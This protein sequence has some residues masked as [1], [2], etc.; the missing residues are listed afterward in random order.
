[1][2][3][4]DVIDRWA[5]IRPEATA[6][7]VLGAG[8]HAEASI[9]YGALL[10]GARGLAAAIEARVAPGERLLVMMP[11]GIGFML[12]YLASLVAGTIAVPV[13]VPRPQRT[14]ERLKLIIRDCAPAAAIV[15]SADM[16]SAY[17]EA[18]GAEG[19]S[20]RWLS[21]DHAAST[22]V[23][24]GARSVTAE[25]VA[26]LQ[27]TSGSTASPKGVKLTHGN[28]LHNQAMIDAVFRMDDR[29]VVLGWLP[30]FHDMGLIGIALHPLYK[31]VRGILLSPDSFVG[32]PL[33][34]LRAISDHGAT[35]SG[36][37]NFAYELCARFV[38][39]RDKRG[40]DLSRLRI[41]FSGSERVRPQ[42]LT[43]FEQAF[44]DCGFR[45]TSFLPCYGMAEATLMISGYPSGEPPVVRQVK[46]RA[47]QEGHRIV[48]AGDDRDAIGL[49][50]VGRTL[51][52]E[53]IVIVEPSGLGRREDREIG[54]VW[55]AGP[56]V[57]DG[58]W[59]SSEDARIRPSWDAG[60]DYLR[61]GDLGYIDD[62]D[63][64]ITGRL[65][66]LIIIRG[67]NIHPEDVEIAVESCLA[68]AVSGRIAAFSVE[69]DNE[70]RLVIAFE[71]NPHRELTIDTLAGDVR[72]ALG[73]RFEV[74]LHAL[75]AVKRGSLPLTS[76]GKLRRNHVR[77]LW[78]EQGL[79]VVAQ[80]RPGDPADAVE[81]QPTRA[82]LARATREEARSLLSGVLID[83]IR[84]FGGMDRL[85]DQAL[86]SSSLPGLGLGSLQIIRLIHRIDECCGVRIALA[87]SLEVS[88]LD[89]LVDLIV[90][91]LGETAQRSDAV[92]VDDARVVAT[93]PLSLGQQG[94]WFA[95]Q[96]SPRS[97][98]YQI[99]RAADVSPVID[100][101]AMNRAL[102][103]LVRCHPALRLAIDP[104]SDGE[105]PMQRL[106]PDAP[107][108]VRLLSCDSPAERDRVLRA[109]ARTSFDLSVAP[110][111]RVSVLRAPG[112]H[113]L[114]ALVAH[115]IICDL[116]S[117]SVLMHD[118]LRVYRD[119]LAGGPQTS[120]SDGPTY[121]DQVLE[122]HARASTDDWR[123]RMD[124]WTR[125]LGDAD[126]WTR[127][128][129]A[130]AAEEVPALHT[131][132]R[133]VRRE[134][135]QKLR[136]LARRHDM[137]LQMVLFAAFQLAVAVL[138]GRDGFLACT[139]TSGRER[140]DR[141]RM[142]G[143]FANLLLF[144]VRVDRRDSIAQW[145]RATRRQMLD[146]YANE[147]PYEEVIRGCANRHA[148]ERPV[149]YAFVM[150]DEGAAD[151]PG[152][153]P[154]SLGQAGGRWTAGE[155]E[156]TSVAFEE[157]HAQF[158]LALYAGVDQDSLLY[159]YKASGP[160]VT[161]QQ[162]YAVAHLVER[163][164]EWLASEDVDDRRLS[165]LQW[166]DPDERRLFDEQAE[167][168]R[169][170]AYL[171]PQHLLDQFERQCV[172]TP[173][174]IALEFE[175]ASTTYAHLQARVLRMASHLRSRGV[176]C[177]TIVGVCMHRS[178]DMV[179]AIYGVLK[180]G[181][182]YLPLD[183][184][185]PAEYLA[186]LVSEA[187]LRYVV[188]DGTLVAQL[189][190]TLPD[191]E[192][193][194]V[195]AP[196]PAVSDDGCPPPL[197][198]QLAYVIFTSGSTGAPK[199][200]MNTHAG[201]VNRLL[202]MQERYRLDES[203]TLVQKT[204]F[205]F[206]VSVWE[207]FWPLM[208]G[209]RLV[210]AR[211][212]GHKDT[213]YLAGLLTGRMVTLVHF[214]PSMLR[215][216]LLEERCVSCRALHTVICSGEALPTRLVREL[217]GRLPVRVEN[218]YGPTEASVDV[219]YYPC[220]ENW[221]GAIQPIG[222]AIANTRLHVLDAA[223][224][225]LP[226]DVTG[227]LCISGVG[228]AR[229]YLANPSLTAE[230]FLPD[231]AG[232]AGARC[233]DT[234]DR[235]KFRQPDLIE[236]CGR[237]D[238]QVK[239]RGLRIELSEIE[240]VL[241]RHACILAAAVTVRQGPAT[242]ATLRYVDRDPPE[243]QWGALLDHRTFLRGNLATAEA[244][245]LPSQLV[246]YCVRTAGAAL[247]VESIQQWVRARLP[248][249]SVPA[250]VVFV[251]QL[252]V[253]A[254]GKLDKAR[255]PEPDSLRPSLR[256]A[257]CAPRTVTER[258]LVD[259]WER[260]LDVRGI[261]IR[262]NFFALGGD[263]IRAL[264]LVSQ[265]AQAGIVFD[266]ATLFAHPT[267]EQLAECAATA[268]EPVRHTPVERFSL[269]G[270]N[271]R[272][273]VPDGI[274]DAY[275]LAVVQAGLIFHDEVAA[276][277]REV[278]KDV[279][280]Y[281]IRAPFDE[282]TFRQAIATLIERHEILRASIDLLNFS[283]PVQ[284]VHPQAQASVEVTRLDHVGGAADTGAFAA[285]L[286]SQAFDWSRPPFIRFAIVLRADA[287]FE[288]FVVFHDLLLDGWSASQLVSELLL[289]Y[290][291]LL[292]GGNPVS[293]PALRVRFAD[294]VA[295]ELEASRSAEARAFFA[296]YLADA[297]E[298]RF[299]VRE[300]DDVTVPRFAVLDVPIALATSD[301]LREMAANCGVGIKHVL[302]AAH[303]A[304][305]SQLFGERDILTGLESNGR[306]ETE[307][308]DMVIGM[309]LNT[310]P[311]RIRCA[312]GRWRDL[313]GEVYRIEQLLTPMRRYPYANMQRMLGTGD[314]V[315]TVFNYVHFHGFRRLLQL[316]HLQVQEARGYGASHFKYRSEFSTDPFSGRIH[317]CL[318]CDTRAVT[319][320]LIHE[321]GRY[322]A[323]VLEVM[324][325]DPEARYDQMSLTR[326]AP[327][328][329]APVSVAGREAEAA[330][331]WLTPWRQ[332]LHH[333]GDRIALV[334]GPHRTSC[335]AMQHRA[336][337]W[338]RA[339]TRRGVGPE[340]C[341]GV[342]VRDPIA[343]AVAILA[344]HL[345]GGAYVPL[346]L[347]HPAERN[348]QIL[349]TGGIAWVIVDDLDALG[350][351]I[352]STI[353][354]VELIAPHGLDAEACE[355]SPD[356]RASAPDQLG[357]D[358]LSPDLLSYVIYTSGSTGSPKGVMVT[359]ANLWFSLRSRMEYYARPEPMVFLM[360]PPF[361]FDSSVGVFFWSLAGGHRLVF[362]ET[363]VSDLLSVLRTIREEAV[364]HVLCTPSYYGALLAE[365]SDGDLESLETIIM[366]G[367]PLSRQL[368]IEHGARLPSAVMFN[369]YGPTEG[370][371]WSSVHRCGDDAHHVPIGKPRDYTSA[372]ILDRRQLAATPG[373]SGELVIGGTGVARGYVNAP[374]ATAAAFVPDPSAAVPGGR[375]YAT[376]DL[377]RG[378]RGVITLLGRND[379]QIKINGY[380][381]E[382]DEIEH[383][384]RQ[385][386]AIED[387]AV[388]YDAHAG[389]SARIIA[390][391][392]PTEEWTSDLEGLDA[393]LP[394]YMVPGR[395]LPLGTLP[396]N[397]NGKVDYRCL[398]DQGEQLSGEWQ[399][400]RILDE[401]ER[402]TEQDVVRALER[403]AA[404]PAENSTHG[405]AG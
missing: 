78:S 295:S 375:A 397:A 268:V 323:E 189:A 283:V 134:T 337:A 362:P 150:Q 137:S 81:G 280:V 313:V 160:L 35:V 162:T 109:E 255:L 350:G 190:D 139:V 248:E 117:L 389:G 342:L 223:L 388:V 172:Q 231:P 315:D 301:R 143:Y 228:L 164:L 229:G 126:D 181:G 261:G 62:G 113:D 324:A 166:L 345:A 257:Y 225:A 338:A 398:R 54:E 403:V 226:V 102:T 296:A 8:G 348:R 186:T 312:A 183:P 364:T 41:A 217:A 368:V 359:H 101:E 151:S 386:P 363:D 293:A 243:P 281:R 251:D 373:Q 6:Y 208:V 285:L 211:P 230:R 154:F 177:E 249:Q 273:K 3:L 122:E 232:S 163:V 341:V 65:K 68:D 192:I 87:D 240:A 167:A 360:I 288:L 327:L 197:R 276:A 316:R 161:P 272:H 275:P 148:H 92:G 277:G 168:T 334:H 129:T 61:T 247:D 336:H 380:R 378:V 292:D 74:E 182:A 145:L 402:M 155:M 376:G 98:A 16:A 76:S 274:V 77:A 53:T 73:Q 180:A 282:P 97:S 147:L 187:G 205:A 318:E 357:P 241:E 242:V 93:A 330:D 215:M 210:I 48:N 132:V 349:T 105:A 170:D 284:L 131:E 311:F 352:A 67:R 224:Q 179:V 103:H 317:L 26:M 66:D 361:A 221:P 194:D 212:R 347:R 392:V 184:E 220:D 12:G 213:T 59:G 156:L 60:R 25:T 99:A 269:L 125:Q 70:E 263:S 367:E 300:P 43:R 321:I 158:P 254:N 209:A 335:T 250:A 13:P 303:V 343:Y 128:A 146:A 382:L 404:S 55:V 40:L 306:L 80:T 332:Q 157:E 64:F 42:T 264:R 24:G 340:R 33:S 5:E 377:A 214:V 89:A 355:P 366:A 90:A 14:D 107:I 202:W 104:V 309:H 18:L 384:I 36:A 339:L 216:F 256:S 188:S 319:S 222:Q 63:L 176:G 9:T 201:I 44:A 262:D 287:E 325:T 260:V 100:V 253:N 356:L 27:Y 374:A 400:Q 219:T 11:N 391:V 314:L 175:D 204:P 91:R 124:F 279:F 354:G 127:S 52:G 149:K 38:R 56:N 302:L 121:L 239:L 29:D 196:G 265:A 370:T 328:S 298:H 198:D 1:M 372:R 394:S 30:L 307:D 258:A 85:S 178:I 17:A 236:F 207:L 82:A 369:E 395:V 371:V 23:A 37:P 206:D 358:Q 49:V 58:Y 72:Q 118:L 169:R 246:A 152:F 138:E 304:V 136:R 203:D 10:Q 245:E 331:V 75:V 57:S 114:L 266:L 15:E 2:T 234:G 399:T 244:A 96:L 237:R 45:G 351:T 305:L 142:V 346:N 110:L 291:G 47:L 88:S 191:V 271:D 401:V 379:R 289:T 111:L 31:G 174:R 353:D 310:V 326:D 195:N 19:A 297:P 333:D 270:P 50:G 322:F 21:V 119:A 116:W 112:C 387:C 308:G 329:D 39:D 235:G 396:L 46:A 86:R 200:A 199:G 171:P 238:G 259:A 252:P 4:I 83:W 135:T 294:H 278:Y 69:V 51:P 193:V 381:V 7:T 165:E 286:R 79:P 144:L 106:A 34:W 84:G 383:A 405:S 108:A 140:A 159:C 28:L 95:Q 365:A 390:Y 22:A 233:Y 185:H 94:I 173:D 153:V 227:A 133:H 32:R 123:R 393:I 267:V 20:L 344:I 71:A 290:D 320:D 115:H 385:L 130:T 120:A 218:L 299:P 141:R